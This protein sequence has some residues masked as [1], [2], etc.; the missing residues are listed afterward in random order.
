MD[1]V[2]LLLP[3][4]IVKKDNQLIRTRVSIDGVVAG[5]ILA[6]LIAC[7]KTDGSVGDTVSISV[8][9]F[10]PDDPNGADYKKI[11]SIT[12][13]LAE[14]FA[15]LSEYKNEKNFKIKKFP[16][17]S[18]ILYD[19]GIISCIFNSRIY[20]LLIELKKGFT[21]YNLIE[22][23]QLP[24]VYSQRIFEI[25][26]SYENLNSDEFE[27]NLTEL[28]KMINSP[29]SFLKDF[30][31]FRTRVLDKAY[32][33]INKKTALSFSWEPIKTGRKVTAIRFIFTGKKRKKLE[34]ATAKAEAEKGKKAVASLAASARNPRKPVNLPQP[35]PLPLGG[36]LATEKELS[37][38]EKKQKFREDIESL[39]RNSSIK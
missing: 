32:I 7:I 25:L 19:R 36:L 21:K 4:K 17:F 16:F 22:F 35:Q 20:S 9:G 2:Q 29:N 38:E 27:I 14:S 13:S 26:K 18:E 6:S 5:R 15:E 31:N 12:N 24:S 34:A 30:R 39:K 8:D 11:N 10:L 23:L 28:H 3:G 33:D 37:L 1:E